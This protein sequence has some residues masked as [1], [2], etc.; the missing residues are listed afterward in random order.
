MEF[1]QATIQDNMQPRSKVQAYTHNSPEP[2]I[3]DELDDVD[4]FQESDSDDGRV[5]RPRPQLPAPNVHMRS[6]GSLISK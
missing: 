4:L 1:S 2:V 3:K 5:Y 6:L